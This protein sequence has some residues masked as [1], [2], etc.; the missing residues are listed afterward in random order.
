M[1]ISRTKFNFLIVMNRISNQLDLKLG[2]SYR[3]TVRLTEE[4]VTELDNAGTH[5]MKHLYNCKA[6]TLIGRDAT[7]RAFCLYWSKKN[8]IELK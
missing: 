2:H 8:F 3:R 7:D 1:E 5:F 4:Q 6:F